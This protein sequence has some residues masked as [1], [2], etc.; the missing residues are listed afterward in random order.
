MPSVAIHQHR[1]LAWISKHARSSAATDQATR[2]AESCARIGRRENFP[3]LTN[4]WASGGDTHGKRA[5][6]LGLVVK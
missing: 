4:G 5:L 2:Q 6:S 1:R 3:M